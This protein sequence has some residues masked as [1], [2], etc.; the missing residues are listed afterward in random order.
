MQ[1]ILVVEDDRE[2][3]QGICYALSKEEYTTLSANSIKEAREIFVK[4]DVD[5]VLLD[6]NLPDGEGFSFCGWLKQQREVPVLFLTAR[7]LEEDALRGYELGA[8]DYITKPFSMKIL[9]Q[10][11]KVV[12]KRGQNGAKHIFDDDYLIIDFDAARVEVGGQECAVT[13]TEF[14]LLRLFTEHAGQLLTYSILLE[15]IWDSGGQFVDKHALAVNVNRLRGKIEDE[16]HKYISNVY[17]MGYQW[18]K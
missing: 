6:V 12:L 17:G 2:L 3:N 13:P 10:K 18:L 1:K 7:D 16:N 14:R 4:E 5:L 8:E 15:R 9:K 11:I